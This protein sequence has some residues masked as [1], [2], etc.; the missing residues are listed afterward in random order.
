MTLKQARTRCAKQSPGVC[1]E[2]FDRQLRDQ[3]AIANRDSSLTLCSPVDTGH[4]SP[5]VFTESN[6][7]PHFHPIF[8]NDI[9]PEEYV[10]E[11]RKQVL[12]V[13]RG[14]DDPFARACAWALLDRYTPDNE[15]DELHDE[16]DAVVERRGKP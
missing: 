13:V 15:L 2:V 10:K 14:S 6:P 3:G 11:N 9:D 8:D 4:G 7:D 16:L 12:A 1:L 5:R